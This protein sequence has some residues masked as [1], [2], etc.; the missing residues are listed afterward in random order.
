MYSNDFAERI[1]IFSR[2]IHRSYREKIAYIQGFSSLTI[3]DFIFIFFPL[4]S[5]RPISFSLRLRMRSKCI[6][7]T[8]AMINTKVRFIPFIISST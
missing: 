3:G 5:S 1:I 6:F 2:D 4:D 7:V 8:P